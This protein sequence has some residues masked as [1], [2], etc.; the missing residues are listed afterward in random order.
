MQSYGTVTI[1]DGVYS[2]QNPLDRP[3][4]FASYNLTS[5]TPV[6]TFE[7]KADAKSFVVDI[8][9]SDF[10]YIYSGSK[11]LPT[12]LPVNYD[13]QYIRATSDKNPVGRAKSF[14]AQFAGCEEAQKVRRR[15]IALSKIRPSISNTS[16]RFAV[17]NP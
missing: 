5:P 16:F 12:V 11:V 10:K 7:P 2:Y 1:Q 15:M 14:I 9:Y 13:K 4:G 6:R 3:T 8:R 17:Q